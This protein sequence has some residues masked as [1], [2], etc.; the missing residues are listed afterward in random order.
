VV[1]PMICGERGAEARTCRLHYRDLVLDCSKPAKHLCSVRTGISRAPGTAELK[2]TLRP[3]V[4][5]TDRLERD[6]ENDSVPL[7][8]PTL[9]RVSGDRITRFHRHCDRCPALARI[10][11]AQRC[12]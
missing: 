4:A 5:L 6:V 9:V 7:S 12:P 8:G 2:P 10:F 11:I 1:G 3:F